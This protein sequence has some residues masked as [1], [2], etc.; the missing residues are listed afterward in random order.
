MLKS[1]VQYQEILGVALKQGRWNAPIH[2]SSSSSGQPRHPPPRKK[3]KIPLWTRMDKNLDV[4]VDTTIY[5]YLYVDVDV[6]VDVDTTIYIYGCGHGRGRG[7]ELGFGG[8]WRGLT[9]WWLWINIDRRWCG[10]R[11]RRLADDDVLSNDTNIRFVHDRDRGCVWVN[12][13][14][15]K[16]WPI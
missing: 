15:N 11:G 1:M 9:D 8:G 5:I 10:G 3:K 6:D 13:A 12:I 2:V 16:F 14:K 7:C 4:D